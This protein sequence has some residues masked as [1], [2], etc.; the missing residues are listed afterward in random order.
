MLLTFGDPNRMPPVNA[1]K[2]E[3]EEIQSRV[4]ALRKGT[5][6]LCGCR[7]E[8]DVGIA[9]VVPLIVPKNRSRKTTQ[10]ASW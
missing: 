6:E 3:R 8:E 9:F 4:A 10:K 2:S 7:I 1:T 5:G